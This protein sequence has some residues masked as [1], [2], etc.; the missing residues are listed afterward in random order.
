MYGIK[1]RAQELKEQYRRE[2]IQA[3][4]MAMAKGADRKELERVSKKGRLVIARVRDR[5]SDPEQ[6]IPIVR[7]AL[8]EEYRE[9]GW[10]GPL[11]Y[12]RCG[13]DARCDGLRAAALEVRDPYRV[14]LVTVPPNWVKLATRLEVA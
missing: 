1:T 13:G 5:A 4:A 8:H 3:L 10:V 6:L 2:H 9:L 7:I 14:R 11:Y 12:A